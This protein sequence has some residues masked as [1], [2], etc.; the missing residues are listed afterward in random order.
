VYNGTIQG[1]K[2]MIYDYEYDRMVTD[3]DDLYDHYIESIDDDEDNA[4]DGYDH[5]QEEY[6]DYYFNI[7]EE[8]DEDE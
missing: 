3:A 1:R 6:Q 4:N 5:Y 7:T 8:L 2:V